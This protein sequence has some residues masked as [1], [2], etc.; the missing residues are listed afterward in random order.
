MTDKAAER[1]T[2]AELQ[3]A[4]RLCDS[5]VDVWD[6]GET[7]LWADLIQTLLPR[8]LAEVEEGRRQ[9]AEMTTERDQWR[10]LHDQAREGMHTLG[11]DLEDVR[12]QLSDAV[13]AT[14]RECAKA[15]CPGCANAFPRCDM[16]QPGAFGCRVWELRRRWP[17][18]FAEPAKGEE[19]PNA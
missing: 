1:L 8:L 4:R 3:E 12:G 16:G 7:Q 10:M 11:K 9:L 14:V 15:V 19:K 2:E 5:R 13:N 18:A 17:E 6:L